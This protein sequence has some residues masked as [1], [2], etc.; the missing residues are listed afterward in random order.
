MIE[1]IIVASF[2][3]S[4]LQSGCQSYQRQSMH[5]FASTP[6]N[7]FFENLSYRNILEY[8]TANEANMNLCRWRGVYCVDQKVVSVFLSDTASGSIVA[9]EWLPPT[10]ELIHFSGGISLF[11]GWPT[12]SL[13]RNLRYL[14]LKS[15]VSLCVSKD[16][17]DLQALPQ[18]ME[19]LFVTFGWFSGQICI[20][21]LPQTMRILY[22]KTKKNV[23]AF[24]WRQKIPESMQ[25]LCIIGDGPRI[26]VAFHQCDTGNLK[27]NMVSKG[28]W[29]DI[30]RLSHH[31]MKFED[32]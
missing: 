16:A 30:V 1:L 26:Q 15:C 29:Q 32:E 17:V 9:V 11:H 10:V 4:D 14:C 25:V 18:Q 19:E 31:Y 5:F 8:F 22:I 12:R 7:F 28:K 24:I 27:S 23:D 13:P 2:F 3:C 21:N 20:N 6:D